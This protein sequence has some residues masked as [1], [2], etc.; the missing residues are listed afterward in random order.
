MSSL[1]SSF[2]RSINAIVIGA[3]GGLGRAFVETLAEDEAVSSVLALSRKPGTYC[4]DGVRTGIINIEDETSI[5][6]AAQSA[7]DASS[8]YHLVIVATGILHAPG[9]SPEK[10]WKAMTAD[11]FIKTYR[12][13]AIGPSLVAKH[14]LHLLNRESKSVF[15]CLSAR[16]G[17]IEDNHLGGWHAYR[18]SKAALNMT[19]RTL[20]IE[21][22]RKNSEAIC[23]GLHPG[24]VDTPLSKPFQRGV[25]NDKLFSP[26]YSANK[27]LAVINGLTKSDTGNTFAWD[28]KRIQF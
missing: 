6:A 21:L 15:S 26:S 20:A 19:L 2:E 12:V 8:A 11:A 14:F 24:T 5:E 10:T 7:A 28:G 27:L 18:A 23:V 16:V 17:S 1:L 4:A 22:S 3:T 25:Q 9:I 13:N